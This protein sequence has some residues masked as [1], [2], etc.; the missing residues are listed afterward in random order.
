MRTEDSG[1]AKPPPAA[2]DEMLPYFYRTRGWWS[3]LGR[4]KRAVVGFLFVAS[5]IGG[6]QGFQQFLQWRYEQT[7]LSR[8]HLRWSDGDKLAAGYAACDWLRAQ[9]AATFDPDAYGNGGAHAAEMRY[10]RTTGDWSVRYTAFEA[11]L[12]LC[13][14]VAVDK[15]GAPS[16][17]AS[18]FDGSGGD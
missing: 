15:L 5:V 3:R 9:P 11:W 16:R 2:A 6:I 8:T 17:L 4:W 1:P 10:W 18:F 14:D 7:Y 13:R 12:Q